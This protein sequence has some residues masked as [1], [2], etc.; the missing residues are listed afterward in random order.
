MRFKNILQYKNNIQSKFL[1]CSYLINFIAEVNKKN[2]AV[3]MKK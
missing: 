1:L 2:Y 3:H